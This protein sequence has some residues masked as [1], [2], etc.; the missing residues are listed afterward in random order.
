MEARQI[1]QKHRPALPPLCSP[2]VRFLGLPFLE[3]SQGSQPKVAQ[4]SHDPLSLHP[5][6]HS[7]QHSET[8]GSPSGQPFGTGTFLQ[9]EHT[10]REHTLCKRIRLWSALLAV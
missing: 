7:V 1:Q 2:R 5:Y 3:I 8:C 4:R 10:G 6:N 9:V